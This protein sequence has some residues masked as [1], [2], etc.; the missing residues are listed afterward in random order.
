MTLPVR[1]L[2]VDDE[3]LAREALRALLAGVEWAQPIREACDGLE[4]LEAF[5]TFRPELV[6]LD[7]QLP[8]LSGIEALEQSGYSSAV[9]FTTAHDDAALAAF[10]L[11]AIDY[12]LKPFGPERFA[13]A[14]ERARIQLAARELLR[15]DAGS[16]PL[17]DRLQLVQQVERPM[18]RLYVRDGRTV[19]PIETR[20]VVRCES[21]GDY[22]I[23]YHAGGQHHAYLN[24]RDLVAVLDPAKFIRIH[25]SQAVNLDYVA[26]ITPRD[27]NRVEIRMKDGTR[28]VASRTGTQLLRARLR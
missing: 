25:R 10:E 24:L 6:F 4:A 27:A 13:L 21:D 7:V 3:P 8:V 14:V 15:G 11:G 28:V 16:A 1:T 9:V 18:T 26:A 22:V 5:R 20:D 17:R 23:I 12:M 19:I 2:I